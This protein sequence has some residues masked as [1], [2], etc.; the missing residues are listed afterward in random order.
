M[1]TIWKYKLNTV[2]AQKINLPINAR[3]LTVQMQHGTPSLWVIV[4][5]DENIMKEH[6]FRTY[7]TGHHRECIS[8]FY[9]G[10]YQDLGGQ[11]VFHVFEG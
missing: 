6:T 3:I 1:K 2:D 4:D 11:L 10:T 8:G 5:P 9:V 7:G